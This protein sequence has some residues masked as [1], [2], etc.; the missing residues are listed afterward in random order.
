MA[1]QMLVAFFSSSCVLYVWEVRSFAAFLLGSLLVIVN[2]WLMEHLF[3]RSDVDQKAIYKSAVL[4][5]VMVA[6]VLL[7]FA[8]VGLNLLFVLSGMA[9]AYG[10]MYFFSARVFLKA[11][12][13]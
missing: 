6:V 12:R 4:R 8:G 5:Y 3:L 1:C 9:L 7:I 13:S 11:L 2:G 10:V